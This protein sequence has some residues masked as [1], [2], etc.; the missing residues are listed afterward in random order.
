MSHHNKMTEKK[1]IV[2][3]LI[4]AV[5]LF[6]YYQ[7]PDNNNNNHQ[8]QTDMPFLSSTP[9]SASTSEKPQISVTSNKNEQ[10]EQQILAAPRPPRSPRQAVFSR[11]KK[12]IRRYSS[13]SCSSKV[14]GCALAQEF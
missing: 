6:G 1:V 4:V 13:S 10:R 8:L 12:S 7:I 11:S 14:C 2:I 5:V 9:T 3:V